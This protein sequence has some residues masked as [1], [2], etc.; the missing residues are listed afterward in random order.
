ML[1]G[2]AWVCQYALD[3]GMEVVLNG[4]TLE[5]GIDQYL[6]MILEREIAGLSERNPSFYNVVPS[7]ELQAYWGFPGIKPTFS[8]GELSFGSPRATHPPR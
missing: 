8:F 2:G 3:T 6:S 4:N 5:G 7:S 1:N